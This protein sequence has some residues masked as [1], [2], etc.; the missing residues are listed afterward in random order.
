MQT[1]SISRRYARA[2]FES[3]LE[4]KRLDVVKRELAEI[5]QI[6]S[7]DHKI[8]VLW[9]SA[10]LPAEKKREFVQKLIP[11]ISPLVLHF[12]YVLMDKRREKLLDQIREEYERFLL[13]FY[14]QAIVSV[15]AAVA[16]PD[17][18]RQDLRT[19][20]SQKLGKIVE[21]VITEDRSL[22]GGL[23]VQWGDMVLDGSIQTKLE[24]LREELLNAALPA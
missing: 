1:E 4:Q 21:L 5:V 13:Q 20:L 24:G 15:R 12:L 2:L 11:E 8:A 10:R 14:N 17:S 16:I 22:L 3:A 19:R 7:D 6:I 9:K 18:V 23:V